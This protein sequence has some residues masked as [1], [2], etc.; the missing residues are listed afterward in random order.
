MKKQ[1]AARATVLKNRTGRLRTRLFN[2]YSV[3]KN[4]LALSLLFLSYLFL[5]R[6]LRV[7]SDLARLALVV[8]AS[9]VAVLAL[10]LIVEFF[11]KTV[12][13]Q[14]DPRIVRYT[15]LVSFNGFFGLVLPAMM[16]NF[17]LAHI[18]R[19]LAWMGNYNTIWCELRRGLVS[20]Y[21]RN[22][23]YWQIASLIGITLVILVAL[24]I[25]G[26][27]LERMHRKDMMNR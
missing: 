10:V 13:L 16:F 20:Y 15:A 3:F 7:D 6:A 26:G 1:A 24:F 21:Y 18:M 11:V 12:R 27:A 19:M 8:Y 23:I 9:I 22:D 17:L 14:N 25:W 2:K 5:S 4:F